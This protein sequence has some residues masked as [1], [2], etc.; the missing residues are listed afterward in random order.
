MGE[1]IVRATAYHPLRSGKIT[2]VS[3]AFTMFSSVLIFSFTACH[4]CVFVSHCSSQPTPVLLSS[5]A[6]EQHVK[7]TSKSF[8][9][10]IYL[11]SATVSNG[12]GDGTSHVN[13]ICDE[14]QT[15]RE[16]SSEVANLPLQH[17]AALPS[18]NPFGK[19]Y[20]V[21]QHYDHTRQ[22]CARGYGNPNKTKMSQKNA[23]SVGARPLILPTYYD[24][25]HKE[26]SR[27]HPQ[28]DNNTS[29]KI[30]NYLASTH[31][32]VVLV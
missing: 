5:I 2:A 26:R 4:R 29:I 11:Q 16:D 18:G 30:C 22:P 9:S 32:R 14:R 27:R 31:G 10:L 12:A 3:G 24:H 17:V 13:T 25:R 20:R 19:L 7:C 28:C 21:S 8:F 6:P 15:S 23:N 1:S